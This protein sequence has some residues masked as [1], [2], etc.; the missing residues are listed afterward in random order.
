ML[1]L[2]GKVFGSD[3]A[4]SGTIGLIDDLWTSDKEAIE[5]KTESKRQLLQAYAPFKLSQRILAWSI[6]GVVLLC[7]LVAF[8]ITTWDFFTEEQIR[9]E[10]GQTIVQVYIDLLGAFKL[11]WA[12]VLIIGFY[13]GGAAVDSYQEK[14]AERERS[15]KSKDSSQPTGKGGR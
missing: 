2:L 4:I 5:A 8:G 6:T 7:F 13:F 3:K 14:K 1:G 10:D 9:N 15:G 12:F 11:D